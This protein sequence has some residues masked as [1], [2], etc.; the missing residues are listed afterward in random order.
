MLIQ[1]IDRV[2][3]RGPVTQSLARA[4]PWK[5]GVGGFGGRNAEKCLHV[6]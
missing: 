3:P 2:D 6:G 1:S 5:H 4:E